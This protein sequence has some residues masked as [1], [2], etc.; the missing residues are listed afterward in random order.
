MWRAPYK[1]GEVLE[2]FVERR[3]DKAAALKLRRKLLKS[4]GA[5]PGTIVTD[6]LSSYRAAMKILACQDRHQ[7][8]RLR[9]NNRVEKSHLPIRRRGRKRQR[10]KPQ[11]ASSPLI[12]RSTARLTSSAISFRARHFAPFKPPRWRRAASA[13]TG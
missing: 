2:D 6:G 13:V 9:E 8:G 10:G 3:R 1:E 7:P 12:L 11:G 4:Q 5:V